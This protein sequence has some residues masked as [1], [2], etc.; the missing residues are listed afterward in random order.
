MKAGIDYAKYLPIRPT[1]EE[2]EQIWNKWK[3]QQ[4]IVYEAGWWWN[5]LTEMKERVVRC[6]CSACGGSWITDRAVSK[7]NTAPFGFWNMDGPVSNCHETIC[8]ECGESVMARHIGSFR[9]RLTE[10][11]RVMTVGRVLGCLVL[12][13]WIVQREVDKKGHVFQSIKPYEAYVVEQHKVVKLTAYNKVIT[14][15]TLTGQWRQLG[16]CVDTWMEEREIIGFT[17]ESLQGTTAENS[18]LDLYMRSTAPKYP[19]SYLRLWLRHPR[20][21][22]L[23][24]CGAWDFVAREIHGNVGYTYGYYPRHCMNG[25]PELNGVNWKE[26]QPTKMLDLNRAELPFL[27]EQRWSGRELRVWR[28]VR[29][30]GPVKLPE[31]M[32]MIRQDGDLHRIEI[33]LE[34]GWPVMKMLRYCKKKEERSMPM[35]ID[36]WNMAE[37]GGIDLTDDSLRWPAHLI[38]QHDKAMEFKKLAEAKKKAADRKTIIEHRRPDFEKTVAIAERFCFASDGILIRPCRTEEELIREGA[39]LSHCVGDYA[40]KICRGASVI[41][42]VRRED[43]P[44]SPWYTLELDLK[45]LQ[46]LQNRGKCNC[47]ETAEV[48]AFVRLWKKTK[49]KKK[50]NAA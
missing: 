32:N 34:K 48:A 12:L 27:I 36:Y 47:Q 49:L 3:P 9:F 29:A 19:V 10:E 39:I 38:R 28:G 20:V 18:K 44:E 5:G 16:R 14:A 26:K 45:D 6:Y 35:L 30:Q 2:A 24:T 40:D 42:L 21:E 43:A 1:A 22:N 31:S 7:N 37:A 50:E 8:P 13:G 11:T 33:A 23:M 4:Y 41:M 17:P 25:I 15:V 46:V